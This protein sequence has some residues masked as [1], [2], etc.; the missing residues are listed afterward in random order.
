MRLDG[1]DA[2]PSFV[3]RLRHAILFIAAHKIY[4]NSRFHCRPKFVEDS[5]NPGNIA[6]I[7][8]WLRPV[9]QQIQDK[10]STAITECGLVRADP[11]RGAPKI[12]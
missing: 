4:V 9:R 1:Y 8:G 6:G 3:I 12:G 5:A 10:R 11:R 2:V 7:R